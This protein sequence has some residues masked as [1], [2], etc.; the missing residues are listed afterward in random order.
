MATTQRPLSNHNTF[1]PATFLISQSS[2]C[3]RTPERAAPT[4]RGSPA[5]RKGTILIIGNIT[6]NSTNGRF[7][8]RPIGI[9]CVIGYKGQGSRQGQGRQGVKVGN[10]PRGSYRDDYISM[11]GYRGAI[12][13]KGDLI[14]RIRSKGRRMH[15]LLWPSGILR[16][17]Y[18]PHMEGESALFIRWV[19]LGAFCFAVVQYFLC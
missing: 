3:G 9:L 11:Y 18:H 7:T 19:C 13:Q 12:G 8:P 14:G 6:H 15:E 4:C 1:H 17:L 5:R 2:R 16:Y 10:K